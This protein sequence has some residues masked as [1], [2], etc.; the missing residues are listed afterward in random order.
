M[1]RIDKILVSQNFGSRK[2]VHALIKNSC[3]K[4]NGEVCR[5]KDYKINPENDEIVV[6]G[7]KLQYNLH[8]YIMMNKPS[9]VLSASNDKNEKTVIDL[10]PDELK[11]KGLFPAG[12]LD[13]DTEGLLIIT[14]DGD[15]AHKMLS[16]KK[17]VYKLYMAVVDGEITEDTICAFEQGIVFADGTK[18]LPAKLEA[19]KIDENSTGFVKICEGKFHQV[20]KMFLTCGLKVVYLKRL[21]VGGLKLDVNLHKGEA[22]KMTELEKSLIFNG[23]I[24]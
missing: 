4:I 6:N 3:V 22:R 2:Q 21:Q 7:E 18:C 19:E 20:K 16:P 24:D 10:L 15:F 12:R 11:R 5:L 14:D 9:G 8:V 1:E 23:T 17:K 13:K